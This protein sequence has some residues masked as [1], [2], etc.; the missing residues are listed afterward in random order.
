MKQQSFNYCS[1]YY[2]SHNR[3]YKG[4]YQLLMIKF[5]NYGCK[6]FYKIDTSLPML[7]NFFSIITRVAIGVTSV[8]MAQ[9]TP[10]KVL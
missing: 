10:K 5:V 4:S 6:K 9:I 1:H 7:K 3:N 8:K 2:N